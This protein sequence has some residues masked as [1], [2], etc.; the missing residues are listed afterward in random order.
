MSGNPDN[1]NIWA[2]ADVYVST[3]LAA[4]L[5]AS[6]SVAFGGDWDLVGL[7]DGDAGFEESRT[8]DVKDHYAWGGLLV[9]TSRS[10]FKLTKKFTVL[11]DN[12]VTRDLIWP[13]STSSTIVVPRPARVM[14]AFEMRDGGQVKRVISANYAEVQPDGA[15]SLNETDLSKVTLVAT[16][17]P[18]A[19]GTLF[20]TQDVPV[21]SSIAITA[22]TLALTVGQI[23]TLVATAT[24]SDASTGIITGSAKWTTSDPAKATVSAGYVS[25]VAAGSANISCTYGGVTATAPSVATVT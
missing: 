4:T 18:D 15:I 7:L 8:E 2:D 24:Y 12:A 11:E 3:N 6:A 1:A 16:I 22:L 9:A 14:I 20:D 17:F 21:I 19:A 13:G 10:K 5:P 25:G 23:K